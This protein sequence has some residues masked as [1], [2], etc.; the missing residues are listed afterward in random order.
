LC[1]SY[2]LEVEPYLMSCPRTQWDA[3]VVHEWVS[4]DIVK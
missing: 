3:S 1:Y 2:M 4:I